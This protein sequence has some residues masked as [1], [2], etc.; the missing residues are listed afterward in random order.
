MRDPKT[1]EQLKREIAYFAGLIKRTTSSDRIRRAHV[2]IRLREQEL[3]VA[4]KVR[5]RPGVSA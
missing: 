4:I 2:A 5:M 1:P 3:T